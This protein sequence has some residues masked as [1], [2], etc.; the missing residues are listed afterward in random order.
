MQ[1]LAQATLPKVTLLKAGDE[2]QTPAVK[3]GQRLTSSGSSVDN[4]VT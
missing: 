1:S 2:V 4:E 3:E